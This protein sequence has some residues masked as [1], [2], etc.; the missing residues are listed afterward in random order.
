MSSR[1]GSPCPKGN[2]YTGFRMTSRSRTWPSI[3]PSTRALRT[4][5]GRYCAIHRAT[6]PPLREEPGRN[7]GLIAIESVVE[8]AVSGGQVLLSLV[9]QQ[10]GDEPPGPERGEGAPGELAEE[11]DPCGQRGRR[12]ALDGVPPREH[13]VIGRVA[14]DQVTSAR[15]GRKILLYVELADVGTYRVKI[16]REAATSHRL[17]DV[18]RRPAAGHRVNDQGAGG[19]EVVE[20]VR[21]DGRRDRARVGDAEGPVVL[22]RPDVVGGRPEPRANRSRRRRSL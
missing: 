10:E 13:R 4:C 12:D 18:E 15:F 14:E 2:P 16:I 19:R 17:A 22:E 5:W 21:H 11:V 9:G 7:E 1:A 6:D 20:R 8:V 3:R